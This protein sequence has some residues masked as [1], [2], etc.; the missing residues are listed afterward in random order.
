VNLLRRFAEEHY[1]SSGLHEGVG[2]GVDWIDRARANSIK[3]AKSSASATSTRSPPVPAGLMDPFLATGLLPDDADR[4]RV[5][6]HLR[7]LQ[8]RR[9][10]NNRVFAHS[11]ENVKADLLYLAERVKPEITLCFAD[12]NFGMYERDVEIADYIGWLQDRYGWPRYIRTTTGKNKGERIIQVMR[13]IRGALPMTAAVQSMNP[14][15]L[16]NIKR[17]NIKLETYREIQKE[18]ESQGMQSYGELILCLP[19]REQ[20]RAS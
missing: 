5:S 10:S 16:K 15:V 3:A 6:L 11:I 1:A 18:L 2:P 9:R 13:K 17:D 4:A 7:L 19:G 14:V 8:L 20:G 12:D